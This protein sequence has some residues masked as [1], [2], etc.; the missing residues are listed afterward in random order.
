MGY[1]F[2]YPVEDVERLSDRRGRVLPDVFL[3]P[4]DATLVDLA[5]AIHSDLPKYLL[6]GIDVRT[7]I[8]LP[9]DYILHDRDVIHLVLARRR[10]R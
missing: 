9:K 8:K 5:T 6:Y 7:G 3:L 4:R 2:V 10:G 1:K